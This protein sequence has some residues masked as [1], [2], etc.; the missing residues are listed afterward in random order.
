MSRR[1]LSSIAIAG[2]LLLLL[3]HMVVGADDDEPL[4]LSLSWLSLVMVI[5]KST[6]P[7]LMTRTITSV[8]SHIDTYH[9]IYIGYDGEDAALVEIRRLCRE[10]LPHIT[11]VI[12]AVFI[13]FHP[14]FSIIG[15]PI[16]GGR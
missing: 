3:V 9:I 4:P 10:T 16:F 13:T 6:D 2:S 5:R 1:F 7:M 8:V 14:S 12:Q 11:G 15:V